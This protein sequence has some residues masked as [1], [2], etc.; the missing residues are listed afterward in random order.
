MKGNMMDRASARRETATHTDSRW[1]PLYVVGG[2]LA[3]ALALLL[4]ASMVSWVLDQAGAPGNWISTLES[5]WLIKLFELN[6]TF[7]VVGF[8]VTRGLNWL[9]FVV[10]AL[11]CVVT[12][13]LFVALRKTSR[14]W[15]LIALVQPFLAIPLLAVTEV[16][17]RSAVMGSALV[18]SGVM[19]RSSIFRRTAAFLGMAA[20]ALLLVGDFGTSGNSHLTVLA[21]PIAIGYLSL[22]GW[23]SLVGRRLIQM[24]ISRAPDAFF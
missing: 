9:D 7:A 22:M 18:I 23:Y 16:Q 8:D 13:G 1:K 24:G 21:V 19:L 6:T 17:G 4:V 15:S 14:I 5:L 12:L 20:G 2:V 10:L 11:A 3:L